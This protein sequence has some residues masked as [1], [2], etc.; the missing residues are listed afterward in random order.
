[1]VR[2]VFFD[3][4]NTLANYE[5][6][7][8][9]LQSQALQE[10]GISVSPQKLLPGLLIADRYYFEENAVSPIL[11]RIPEEQSKIW[12]RYESSL[13]TEAGIDIPG[14]S[15][16]LL[17]IMTRVRELAQGISFALFDDVLPTLKTLESQDL[18]LGLLTNLDRD[19]NP[20]CREL[21]IEPYIDFVVTSGEVGA[22]KPKPPIFLTALQRAGVSPSDAVHV[23][24]QYKLDIVGARDVGI[25]PILI[26][27]HDLSP[28]VTD[29]PRIR[30]LTE[31]PAYLG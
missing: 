12:A 29:C 24:D 5:P 9:E 16:I 30:S 8:E 26:D 10:F 15:D 23:G 1:M 18:T 21:G 11:K 25:A 6:A 4:F 3:W 17:R 31:L 13:L 28:E 2:A 19:M 27:R 7:R 22:D 14:N 20:I